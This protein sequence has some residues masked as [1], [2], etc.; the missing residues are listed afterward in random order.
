MP[1]TQ[2]V[3]T[4]ADVAIEFDRDGRNKVIMNAT[5][6]ASGRGVTRGERLRLVLSDEALRVDGDNPANDS[7]VL[8]ASSTRLAFAIKNRRPGSGGVAEVHRSIKISP[9]RLTIEFTV[10]SQ[11]GLSATSRW[12]ASKR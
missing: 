10:Y 4:K 3:E 11:G 8:S 2:I 1:G 7:K 9:T 5:L 6:T 12:T